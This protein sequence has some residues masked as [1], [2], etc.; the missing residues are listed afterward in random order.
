MLAPV[1]SH[2]LPKSWLVFWTPTR[3]VIVSPG[4]TSVDD[5]KR[6]KSIPL[7]RQSPGLRCAEAGAVPINPA[8]IAIIAASHIRRC[9]KRPRP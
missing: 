7:T 3:N 9:M 4:R 6:T 5:S 1:T 2:G 8:T